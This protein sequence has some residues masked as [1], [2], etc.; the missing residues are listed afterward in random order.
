MTRFGS[1]DTI[2]GPRFKRGFL[3]RERDHHL[4]RKPKRPCSHCGGLSR[5]RCDCSKS[6]A[7]DR[8]TDARRGSAHER[9]YD[10]RWSLAS[11]W[12]LKANPLCV[13]CLGLSVTTAATLTDHIV[14]H[15]GSYSIFWDRDNWQSLCAHCHDGPKAQL[16]VKWQKGL[17]ANADLDFR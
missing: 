9:G 17:I 3:H 7:Q 6:K 4:P 11:K 1:V 16:E 5:G 2:K 12:H 8:A 15:N 10:Y 14:P 13:R